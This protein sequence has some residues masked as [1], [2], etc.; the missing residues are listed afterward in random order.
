MPRAALMLSLS[1]LAAA[2]L[3]ASPAAADVF[4]VDP[5]GSDGADG[6]SGTPW[7]TLQHAADSV[8]AGDT[9]MVR[10]GTY[11]GFELTTSGTSSARIELLG[12]DGVVID[13]TASGNRDGINLEGASYVTIAGFT[14]EEAPRAGIRAVTSRGVIIR[15]NVSRRNGVF[16][17]L[18]GFAYDLTIADN[19]TSDNVEQHGIYVSNSDEPNDNVV[20]R[21]NE[22]FGNGRSGIQFN[23]DCSISAGIIDG[24]LIEGNYV[25]DNDVKGLSLISMQDSVVQN[26]VIVGNGL[27][28]GAGGIHLTDEPGC[29]L[30]SNDNVVVNN[31]IIEPRIAGIR[32]TDDA[33][34]NVIFNNVIV[35]DRGAVDEVGGNAIDAE[36]N[37]IQS[38]DSGLFRDAAGM[39]YRPAVG[40]PLVDTGRAD[41]MGQS[42]PPS[43]YDGVSRPTG[44]GFDIGA[45]EHSDAP[46]PDAGSATDG[47]TRTDGGIVAGDSGRST[48]DAGTAAADDGGC[49]CRTAGR[50]APRPVVL[51]LLFG[52]VAVARRRRG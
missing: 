38:N 4:Q 9:V 40:G 37:L 51:L 26:N 50:G 44:A 30:P 11:A 23:G 18:T 24:S 6:S 47:G 13:G 33:M 12:G 22:T 43:D 20:V 32:I 28:S 7:A 27:V 36:S 16:G 5:G 14:V 34:G 42:A 39:D 41:F 49:G 46:R 8:G 3:F 35:S 2:V 29:G 21:G 19:V 25:H 17:I 52:A 31:T 1:L 10:A 45:Y 15:N 48:G